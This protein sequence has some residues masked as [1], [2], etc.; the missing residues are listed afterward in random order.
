MCLGLKEA[1]FEKP[2]E[3]IEH[4][5]LLYVQG[6]IDGRPISRMLINVG[7]VINLMLYSMFKKLEREDD[8]VI[9]INLTPNGMGGSPMEARGVVSMELTVGSKSLA[10]TFCVVEV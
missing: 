1:M 8:E 7:A 2:E 4:L 10:I 6:H 5:K 3:S 9:K